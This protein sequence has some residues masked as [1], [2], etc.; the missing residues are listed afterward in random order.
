MSLDNPSA[1]EHQETIDSLHSHRLGVFIETEKIKLE[2]LQKATNDKTLINHLSQ[3]KT[4][5]EKFQKNVQPLPSETRDDLVE[6]WETF[7]NATTS[8]DEML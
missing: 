6:L 8:F 4:K 2:L 3:Q 1:K 7:K 5:L